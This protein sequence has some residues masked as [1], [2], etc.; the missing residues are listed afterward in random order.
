MFR[1]SAKG[2]PG[3]VCGPGLNPARTTEQFLAS[4][5][6]IDRMKREEAGKKIKNG[7]CVKILY[8]CKTIKKTC[9]EGGNEMRKRDISEMKIGER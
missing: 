7:Y 6:G 9:T 2:I 8:R 1:L 3:T 5:A 4:G